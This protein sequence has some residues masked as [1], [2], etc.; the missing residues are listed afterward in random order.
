MG[1]LHDAMATKCG[2][3]IINNIRN[4]NNQYQ[5]V[6]STSLSRVSD[7]TWP[8]PDYVCFDAAN[9][10]TYAIEF[11]PT[12][13]TKREYLCGLGQSLS[14]LQKHMYAGLIVPTVA[15][16]G[17]AISAFI[18]ETLQSPE[19]NSIALS[20]FEYDPQT[21]AVKLLRPITQKRNATGLVVSSPTTNTFWCWWR[22]I[23]QYELYELLELSFKYSDRSGDIYTNNVFPDF[24]N[25]LKNGNTLTWEGQKR[26][27]ALT[28]N[29]AQL[30]Q[31]Y[32]IPLNQLDLWNPS[33]GK[34]TELGLKLLKIGKLYG[35]DSKDFISAL[36]YL[37]LIDGKHLELIKKV[38]DYQKSSVIPN[39]SDTFLLK[40]E[41]SLQNA[42]CIGP[43]KP[44]ARRG[45]KT[46]KPSYIRDEPKLW[47]KL[48][49]MELKGKKQY[50][51]PN[52]GYKFNW[53]II[54]DALVE[55]QRILGA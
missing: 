43:R 25:D 38:E 50:F 54:S 36:T 24:W 41:N 10:C 48:G 32:K 15:D 1:A 8:R 5:Q 29:Q 45:N 31:N 11:K 9:L 35:P 51:F 19:F 16:D 17:F 4:G 55:G 30:K 23:S 52:E 12:N 39:K 3:Q 33:T 42:G 6:F 26:K 13:Q 2:D 22:D 47:N 40:L 44:A 34:L 53:H 37:V 18:N 49:L 27:P 20:L 21:L 46:A 14:Y 28:S 7:W